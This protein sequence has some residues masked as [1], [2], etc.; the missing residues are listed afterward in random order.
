MAGQ[1][2]RLTTDI[3]RYARDRAVGWHD[4]RL[5]RSGCSVSA[6]GDFAVR[7]VTGICQPGHLC[8]SPPAH[9]VALPGQLVFKTSPGCGPVKAAAAIGLPRSWY[10]GRGVTGQTA[11]VACGGFS[12]EVW[13]AGLPSELKMMPSAAWTEVLRKNA[14]CGRAGDDRV[15]EPGK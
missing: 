12:I 10:S 7:R 6:S 11:R 2:R 8:R 14:L 13:S 15:R 4:P 1:V 5:P 9:L 3:R